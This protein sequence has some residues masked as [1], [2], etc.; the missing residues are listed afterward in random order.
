MQN[1][2]FK[3]LKGEVTVLEVEPSDMVGD[4]KSKI[5]D[6]NRLP[7]D[8]VRLTFLGKQL[9]DTRTLSEYDIQEVCGG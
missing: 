1:S 3:T 8:G 4:V 7:S 6:K 5:Q 2:F 9:E